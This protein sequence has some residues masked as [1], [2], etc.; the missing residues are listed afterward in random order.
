MPVKA[1]ECTFQAV[2]GHEY[3]VLESLFKT[4][5][6]TFYLFCPKSQNNGALGS[7]TV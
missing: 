2:Y 7:V 6:V 1:G 3:E 4:S 5:Q